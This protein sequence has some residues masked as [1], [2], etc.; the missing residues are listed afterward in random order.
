VTTISPHTDTEGN[1]PSKKGGA[2]MVPI[3]F[4][5]M[6]TARHAEGATI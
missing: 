2:S 6:I 1:L 3:P 5:E 4:Q